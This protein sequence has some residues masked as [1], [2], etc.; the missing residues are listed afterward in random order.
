V[1]PTHE[2][3]LVDSGWPWGPSAQRIFDVA[4]KAGLK[5][6]DYLITTHFHVDHFGGAGALS[7]LMPVK[8]IWDNG[9]PKGDPD[10]RNKDG[11]PFSTADY[12]AINAER[13]VI[14]PGDL[15]P[16]YSPRLRLRCVGAKK[17]FLTATGSEANPLCSAS[18]VKEADPSDNANSVCLLLTF[19]N[20]R[21]F[22]GGDLTWNLEEKLVCPTNLIGTVDVYQ[23]NHHGMDISNNP[24]L[25]RSLAP[26]ISVMNN[27]PH[28]GGSK[29]TLKTLRDTKS[30]QAMFQ[31][32]RDLRGGS[33]FN[34]GDKF[35]ANLEEKCAGNYIK[36]SVDAAGNRYTISIPATG[37]SQTYKTAKH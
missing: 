30:I 5:Q 1:T 25:V 37:F 34:T 28:K 18:V 13:R 9:A 26:T 19:G 16:L 22:D 8:H 35:I 12:R 33:E 23:V 4:Q 32:H 24:L 2:S 11:Q 20:F 6:I 36:C 7:K 21:F 17:Q 29:A 27:G 3:V 14:V 10:N 15:V 31:L